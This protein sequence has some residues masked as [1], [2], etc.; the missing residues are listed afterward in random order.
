M[1]ILKVVI[2]CDG[3]RSVC[4]GYYTQRLRQNASPEPPGWYAGDPHVHV[5]CGVGSGHDPMTDVQMLAE[6][7]AR[8][9]AVVSLLADMGNGEVRFAE[10][11]SYQGEWER[12][13]GLRCTVR[14]ALGCRVHFD[15][16][17][18]NLRAEGHRRPPHPPG[19]EAGKQDVR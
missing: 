9:L 3:F 6:M 4:P 12:L 11:E 19:P 8:G 13:L 14:F 2:L 7:K 10:K 1:E 5:D 15:P 16:Q 17:G 18:S